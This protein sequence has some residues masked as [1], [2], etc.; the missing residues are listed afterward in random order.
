MSNPHESPERV[1]SA[2][3]HR[4]ERKAARPRITVTCISV[5]L[6][7]PQTLLLTCDLEARLEAV[8]T[9]AQLASDSVSS[10]F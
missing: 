3:G 4:Q 8:W 10:I 6:L 7:T 1:T 9:Y 5:L 2:A